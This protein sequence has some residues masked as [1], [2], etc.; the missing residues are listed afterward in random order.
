[1]SLT[2]LRAR[3]TSPARCPQS[4]I[5]CTWQDPLHDASHGEEI[6]YDSEELGKET[7]DVHGLGLC[8]GA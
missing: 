3:L 1:M 8:A 4:A 7:I 6:K 2:A 5:E